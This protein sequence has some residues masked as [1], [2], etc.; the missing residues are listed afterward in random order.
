MTSSAD[1]AITVT[2]NV[3]TGQIE[4]D[5]D[6]WNDEDPRWG[7]V[8]DPVTGAG[9]L[10]TEFEPWGEDEAGME[11]ADAA[12]LGLG[13]VVAEWDDRP[14]EEIRYGVI[15]GRAEWEVS[16]GELHQ[17]RDEAGQA[18]DEAGV[19]MAQIALGSTPAEL[20]EQIN[21]MGTWYAV[22]RDQLRVMTG[23]Q[24]RALCAVAILAARAAA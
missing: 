9:I 15:K 5:T 21:D 14:G 20:A 6:D 4:I 23:D 19:I 18:G 7:V 2:A 24:A 10:G 17:L 22:S 11:R 16:D 3:V 1:D 12:I 13:L 8:R